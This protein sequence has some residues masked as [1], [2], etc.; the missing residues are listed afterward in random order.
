MLKITIS[1]KTRFILVL[2]ISVALV[3]F[4]WMAFH[5]VNK[6][7]PTELYGSWDFFEIQAM[8]MTA[9]IKLVIDEQR[10]TSVTTCFYDDKQ[11]SVKTVSPI[12][13]SADE[14]QVLN[15]AENL[16]QYSPGFLACKASL[17]KG[18]LIYR[19]ENNQLI[20]RMSNNET[21]MTLSRSGDNFKQAL[22]KQ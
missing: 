2:F 4:L 11:V 13:I 14:I 8:G 21:V 5:K 20:L 7:P 15:S 16:R 12:N 1:S 19:L 17:E 18:V 22:I 3:F 10:I 9:Q 6:D